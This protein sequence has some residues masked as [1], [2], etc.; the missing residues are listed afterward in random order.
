ML[1]D[2]RRWAWAQ[3]LRGYARLPK[4]YEGVRGSEREKDGGGARRVEGGLHN[5]CSLFANSPIREVELTEHWH[6]QRPKC[7][8]DL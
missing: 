6:S 2:D 8:Q 5:T 1:R 4:V 3:Q 7:N